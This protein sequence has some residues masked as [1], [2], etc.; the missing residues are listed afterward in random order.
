[1]SLAY[2]YHG[3]AKYF[4]E[5]NRE[6]TND[7]ETGLSFNHI[8][9]K[10]QIGLYE[11]FLKEEKYKEAY[12]VVRN[13]AKYFPANPNRLAEVIRLAIM[14]ENYRHI[15]DYYEI[16]RELDERTEKIINHVCSGLYILGK[17]Y[18]LE[19]EFEK[20]KE[21]FEKVAISCQGIT[22]FLRAI[23]EILVEYDFS[24]EAQGLLKRFPAESF[25]N[26]DYLISSSL[27]SKKKV[28]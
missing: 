27:L 20:G 15:E 18:F 28:A 11:I 19:N 21:I 5:L 4:L 12:E 7:Y 26:E 10:C 9:Y 8:H 3:Q 6:A 17:Y 24:A 13:I 16:F 23:I 25:S 22:K 1:S 14:T 2:F